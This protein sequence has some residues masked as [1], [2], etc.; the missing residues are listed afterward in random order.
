MKRRSERI[1]TAYEDLLQAFGPQGWWPGRSSFEVAVGAVLTQNTAWRNAELAL[2]NLRSAR[3]LSPKGMAGADPRRL[4]E[5]IRPAGFPGRKARTLLGLVD[6]ASGAAGGWPGFLKMNPEPM[7]T[8][9]TGVWGIGPETADAIALYA[10][11]HPTFVVDEYTRRYAERHGLAPPGAGYQELQ[12]LF[13][14]ALGAD[15]AALG[16]FHALAVR[17]GKEFCRTRPRCAG[18]PLE[19]D[20]PRHDHTQS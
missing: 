8:V 6:A 12:Q 5:L 15:A 20:L 16:E 2:R 7:R 19:Q 13:R 17:L 9:L 4:E 11:G 1:L 14:S 18:C 3:L 10:A